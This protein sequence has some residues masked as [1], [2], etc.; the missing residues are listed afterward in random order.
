MKI[1]LSTFVGISMVASRIDA[2]I[3]SGPASVLFFHAD[4]NCTGIPA[5]IKISQ[6]VSCRAE[7]DDYCSNYDLG[8]SH[9]CVTNL[10]ES[11]SNTFGESPYVVVEYYTDAGCSTIRQTFAFLAD[12]NCHEYYLV[13]TIASQRTTIGADGRVKV[14]GFS[15]EYGRCSPT[16]EV[17][18]DQPA[19]NINT[20]GCIAT[21]GQMPKRFYSVGTSPD[22][23][24]GSTTGGSTDSTATLTTNTTTKTSSA[25]TTSLVSS[26][27]TLFVGAVLSTMMVVF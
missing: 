17:L 24:S 6:D 2:D 8:R 26:A 1:S 7:P 13:D 22:S 20:G 11:L 16:L 12:G 10:A 14:E 9:A 21:T 15:N 27:A 19:A 5:H 25:A 3:Y 23:S 4:L 18:L